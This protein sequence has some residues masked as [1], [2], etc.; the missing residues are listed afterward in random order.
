MKTSA[1]KRLC[2]FLIAALS[3]A[4]PSKAACSTPKASIEDIILTSSRDHLLLYFTVKDCFSEDIRKAVQ[5]G[6]KTTFN[7]YVTLHETRSILWNKE[8]ASI[9]VTHHILYDNLK[10]VYLVELP[11]RGKT[12]EFKDMDA[13]GKAMAEIVGLEVVTLDRLEK[14]KRYQVRM[15]A[16]LDRITL[17]F[18]LHYIFFFVSFWDYETD[19]YS[20]EFRY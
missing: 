12:M 16:E 18:R 13:A 10:K 20:V 4:L 5:N 17:P 6:I 11:E 1:M 8:I 15:K 2:L 9:L 19:W 3:L 14:G 7:F